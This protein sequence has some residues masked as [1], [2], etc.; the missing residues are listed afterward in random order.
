M[1]TK[2]RKPS[3]KPDAAGSSADNC[4]VAALMHT[5]AHLLKAR[6]AHEATNDDFVGEQV[7]DVFENNALLATARQATSLVGAAFQL[8]IVLKRLDAV[9]DGN[10]LEVRKRAYREAMRGVLSPYTAVVSAAGTAPNEIIVDRFLGGSEL[11]VARVYRSRFHCRT[12]R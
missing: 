10:E 5:A 3:P 9:L 11:L 6:S 8:L 4:P 7:C 1:Q 12:R 2:K